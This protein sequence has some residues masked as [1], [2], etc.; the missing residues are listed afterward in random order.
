MYF[1]RNFGDDVDLNKGKKWLAHVLGYGAISMVILGVIAVIAVFG[2]SIM[3]VF[4]F[5]YQSVWK[6]ILFFVLV[7]I[8]GFPLE[9]LAK[10]LPE[11]LLSLDRMSVSQARM[12]FILL[13]T[14][15]TAVSM[16]IIDFF[17]DSV[18]ATMLSI[19]VVALLMAML[20]VKDIGEVEN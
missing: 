6:V 17:M 12:L 14:F 7:T 13:D 11:A 5:R 3:R 2:G 18:S 20:S 1:G 16:L 4:G 10:A 8:S 19:I 9:I 15:A